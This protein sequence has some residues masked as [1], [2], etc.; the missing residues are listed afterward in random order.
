MKF[1]V[2]KITLSEINGF[3][4]KIYTPLI[5]AIL[6]ILFSI[7]IWICYQYVFKI[8]KIEPSSEMTVERIDSDT[9]KEVL[10]ERDERRKK[11]DQVWQNQYPDP[12]N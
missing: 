10:I 8:I 12:F 4:R 5:T 1:N 11:L 3:I 6:I 9:L 2:K 7:G